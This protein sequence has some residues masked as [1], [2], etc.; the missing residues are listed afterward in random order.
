MVFS[1]GEIEF[2]IVEADRLAVVS[3]RVTTPLGVLLA[4]AEAA[5]EDEGRTLRLVGF[6][7]QPETL[8]PN[9][10]GPA[11]LRSLVQ[12]LRERMGYD[13]VVIEG[14]VRTTGAGPGRRPRALR[15]TG[16]DRPAP[17]ERLR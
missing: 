13:T 2:E 16:D 4:M 14:A 3:V 12:A 7:V 11:N 5:E 1:A 17:N 10:L 6:H 9:A 8:G 15:F